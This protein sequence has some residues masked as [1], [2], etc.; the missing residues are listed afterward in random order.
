MASESLG[1]VVVGTSFGVLTH[2]RALR[3][4]GFAVH[5][6]VGRDPERTE[7]RAKHAGVPLGLTS[8][9]RALALPGVDVVS[10]ATPPH[11]HAEIVL[12]AL[13]AGKH[14]LCE[15]PF[16]RDAAEARRML[17][18]AEAAG[19]VHLMGNEFRFATAQA[20]ATRALRAGAIGKP[21]LATFLLEI[22]GLADPEAGVPGWWSDARQG[23]GW[24]GGYASHVVDEIRLML[25]EIEGVCA[26][27]ANVA[28]RDWTAED[29]YSVHFRTRSGA[30]GVMQS[31]G[32]V[33]GPPIAVIRIAGTKGTL[34]IEGDDVFVADASGSRKLDVPVDLRNPAPVP[35]DPALLATSY[36]HLHSRGTDLGP[37]TKLFRV[38]RERIRGLPVP[39]DPPAATFADGFAAQLALDAIRRSAREGRWVPIEPG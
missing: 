32:A 15:K 5:A 11:T 1:A 21:R 34:W 7:E 30:T 28:E 26:T 2:L 17:A 14:V 37:F 20:L 31:S 39:D 9:E 3:A 4:A 35:V 13:R 29:S 16:A 8:L 24:L 18:A 38:M 19:V 27:V 36:D 12:A 22:P 25:G 6:L 10:V 33:L 23:G